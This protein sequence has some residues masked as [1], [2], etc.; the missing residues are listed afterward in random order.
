MREDE[1]KTERRSFP[2]KRVS[3]PM[4]K[5]YCFRRLCRQSLQ[6]FC[7][8]CRI[9]FPI[10]NV[11]FPEKE[12]PECSKKKSALQQFLDAFDLNPTK[13]EDTDR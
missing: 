5:I 2:Y 12:A 4:W 1:I 9:K 10:L 7:M 6:T 8:T 3:R 13:Q 11:I